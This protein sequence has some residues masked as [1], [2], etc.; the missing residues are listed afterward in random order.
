MKIMTRRRTV[1]KDVTTCMCRVSITSMN[2]TL[3]SLSTDVGRRNEWSQ[4]QRG[5][6]TCTEVRNWFCPDRLTLGPSQVHQSLL[7]TSSGLSGVFVS[8][9][10]TTVRSHPGHNSCSVVTIER[11]PFLCPE[12]L[13]SITRF[14]WSGSSTFSSLRFPRLRFQISQIK[15]QILERRYNR[16]AYMVEIQYRP[17]PY[18]SEGPLDL[19]NIDDKER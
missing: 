3:N 16:D 8:S 7:L 1:V 6:L 9:V 14:P 15:I 19:L 4:S 18:V 5:V 13:P 2:S 10:L 17:P 11:Y 12:S